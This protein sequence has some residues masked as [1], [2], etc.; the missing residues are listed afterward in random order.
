[1]P[2]SV[3][4]TAKRD[5]RGSRRAQDIDRHIGARLRERRIALGLT[6]QQLAELL[7][8]AYQQ[9]HKYE[10]GTNRIAAGRLY[11]IAQAIGVDVGYFLEGLKQPPPIATPKQRQMLELARYFTG[12]SQ[13]YQEAL[14]EL[15]RALA[16][17]GGGGEPEPEE[18][19]EAAAA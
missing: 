9:V 3:A 7:G 6:Q 17:S 14:C 16:G 11:T 10:K 13:R 12:L 2:V 5:E 8:I 4:R 1:M 18:S 19:R 15:A